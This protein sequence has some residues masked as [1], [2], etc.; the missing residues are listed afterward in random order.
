MKTHIWDTIIQQI[1]SSY[2][3]IAFDKVDGMPSRFYLSRHDDTFKEMAKAIL[4]DLSSGT[5]WPP[6]LL[7]SY[8]ARLCP[9]TDIGILQI[10]QK[11]FWEEISEIEDESLLLLHWFTTVSWERIEDIPTF[12]ALRIKDFMPYIRVIPFQYQSFDIKRQYWENVVSNETLNL[13]FGIEDENA[14]TIISRNDLFNHLGDTESFIIKVLMWGYPTKGRG[15]NIENF[16]KNKSEFA[17]YVKL[18]NELTREKPFNDKSLQ[19]LLKT[20]GLKLSTVSKLLYFKKIK[21]NDYPTLIL[22][23]K[24]INAL[25]SNRFTDRFLCSFQELKYIN[26]RKY[27]HTYIKLLSELADK[28]N[29]K[30]DQ[31]ELFLFMH[32]S[33]LKI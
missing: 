4:A 2:K 20:K 33:N 5:V 23:Q 24:V 25:T 17:N 18:F 15:K 16:L 14:V 8:S 7:G 12:D 9:V 32:G 1:K 21:L 3:I 31:I 30:P 11:D 27:Y 29:V 28:Y 22:D 13:I 26:A 10:D 6:R 19:A